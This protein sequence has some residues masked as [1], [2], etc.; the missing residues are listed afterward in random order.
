MKINKKTIKKIIE[1]NY[2]QAV[3]EIGE[4]LSLK[5]KRTLSLT[6]AVSFVSNIVDMCI[7]K[8]ELD[9]MAFAFDIAN[10]EGVLKLYAG[11]TLSNNLEADYDVLYSTGIYEKV[12]EHIDRK[13]YDIL[14]DAANSQV[15]YYRDLF[16]SA[17]TTKINEVADRFETTMNESMKSLS[18][19]SELRK[20]VEEYISTKAAKAKEKE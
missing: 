1:N 7:D 4:G 13:Q 2:S 19:D 11:I 10:R 6:D 5:V 17:A 3:V 8:A 9:Y 12:L 20:M 18:E 16:S 14:L 15:K